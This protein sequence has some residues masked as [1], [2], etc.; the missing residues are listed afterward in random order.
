MIEKQL[1]M[2][3]CKCGEEF[4]TSAFDLGDLCDSCKPQIFRNMA[5]FLERL[6]RLTYMQIEHAHFKHMA[7]EDLERRINWTNPETGKTE[8]I[9]F[10]R[11]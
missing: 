2:K 1:E 4:E 6:P 8:V 10:I 3:T 5:D 11:P 7:N 9:Y